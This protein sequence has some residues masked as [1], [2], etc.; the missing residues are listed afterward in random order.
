MP[1]FNTQQARRLVKR[2]RNAEA[3]G[4]ETKARKLDRDFAKAIIRWPRLPSL[5]SIQLRDEVH[6]GNLQ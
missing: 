6:Q 1:E 4:N 5:R 3:D 2:F